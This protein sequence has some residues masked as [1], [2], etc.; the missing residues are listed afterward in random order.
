MEGGGL[1][2]PAEQFPNT[3][4]PGSWFDT[5][6]YALPTYVT[7]AICLSATLASLLG[8][9]ET[10]DRDESADVTRKSEMTTSEVLRSPGV[11]MVLYIYG[12]VMLLSLGYT[13]VSPVFLYTDIELG[14]WGF[15]DQ[16]IAGYLAVAGASQSLWMLIAFP[17]LQRRLGTGNLLRVCL[18]VWCVLFA[19]FP[20]MN[21]FLRQHWT[22]AFWAI[23]PPFLVLGSGVS[24]SFGEFVFIEPHLRAAELTIPACIQ[25][26]LNDISPS[27]A[28]LATVNA[29]G[30]TV[31]SAVRAFAPV[32][33]TSIYA[34]GIKLGWLHGHLVWLVLIILTLVL[35]AACF[36]LPK[37]AEGRNEEPERAENE[38]D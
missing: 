7:G 35:N 29:L 9:K 18:V 30:L 36:Y 13:A 27:S 8:L 1:A 22:T 15:S 20:V 3:F 23:A 19:G 6:S 12:H 14:G 10:L 38:R 37:Q 33:F 28:V 34:G 2:N 25:L 4:T 31:N 16:M 24:M 21:A 5:Y 26:C 17:P 11:P 32:A